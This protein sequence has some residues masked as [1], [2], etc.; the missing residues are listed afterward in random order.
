MEER[1]VGGSLFWS[2]SGDFLAKVCFGFQSRSRR[3]AR[4]QV[5]TFRL[6][7]IACDFIH[8]HFGSI[9]FSV[10]TIGMS[11]AHELSLDELAQYF[12]LPVRCL[13]SFWAFSRLPV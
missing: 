9:L 8:C 2:R 3:F 11:N 10:V 12:H 5:V 4:V 6:D 13:F 1:G 7:E